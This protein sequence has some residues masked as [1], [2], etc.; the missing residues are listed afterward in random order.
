M[1]PFLIR[2][3]LIAEYRTDFRKRFDGLLAEAYRL[4][5]DPYAGDC[6]PLVLGSDGAGVVKD[7]GRQ[8]TKFKPGGQVYFRI[9]DLSHAWLVVASCHRLPSGILSLL[10]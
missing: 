10:L 8:A 5:A 3:V 6:F 4:G 2:R 1:L 7:L 9:P